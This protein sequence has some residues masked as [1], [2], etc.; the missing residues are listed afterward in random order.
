MPIRTSPVRVPADRALDRPAGAP[1]PGNSPSLPCRSLRRLGLIGGALATALAGCGPLG[2]PELPW[3]PKEA[4]LQDV[5][6]V[7]KS[8]LISCRQMASRYQLLHDGFDPTFRAVV[9]WNPQLLADAERLDRVPQGQRGS[10]HCVPVVIKDN[11]EV[12]GLPTTAGA[13]ALDGVL[14]RSNA[15]VAQRLITAGALVLGKTNMPDF[16]LDG[17]NT[18]S[19]F[20]GQTRNPYDQG[21]TVYGSSGGTAAAITASLGVIG[22]GTDTFGSLV[23]PASATGIVAI[24]PTQGLL[25]SSGILPLMSLQDMPGP[26]A[27][28]V[29]DAA[30]ALE[31][32]VDSQYAAKGS[33]SYTSGLSSRGLAGLTIGYDPAALQPL[34]APPLVP[35]EDVAGLFSQV[36]QNLSQAGASAKQVS[37]LATQLPTLQAAIDL[38]FQCMPVDFKQSLN[39]HLAELRGQAPIKSL[40]DI[41]PTRKY[42]DSAFEFLTQA[43]AQT[44]TIQSSMACQK[45]LEAKAA[46]ARSITA[47]M[48]KEGVDLLIYPAANQP[49]Y[50][51]GT[52]PPKGW[53]GFQAL[54]SNTGLPSLSMP[55]G[56]AP[57]AGAP[58]GFILL[59]RGYQEA[60]LIQA[61]YAYQSR[62]KPR[63]APTATWPTP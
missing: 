5:R 6:G 59:A 45:Y 63:S 42:L 60:K 22:L 34:P 17:T 27:R 1:G 56:R 48:D 30:A 47:L 61:A 14:A 40:A 54:S 19:S 24:R 12:I 15:E 43:E 37:V 11:I 52:T 3:N 18:L 55:M 7:V 49:A 29:E 50:P 35:S 31:L 44:D 23:Q 13:R 41:I 28:T 9:S 2:A 46:A 62:F 58:V 26:M 32:L 33:Q 51:I 39:S 16:A 10:F 20:G 4:S 53:F 36:L 21:L 8:G 57:R 38:S 25:P